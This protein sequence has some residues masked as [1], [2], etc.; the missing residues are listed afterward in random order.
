M[1]IDHSQNEIE[2]VLRNARESDVKFIRLWFTDILGNLKGFAITIEDL[3]DALL[4]GVGFDGA[5][6]EGFARDNESDVRAF[7]DPSTFTILPWRPKDNAT[8]R[9]FCDIHTPQGE[10]FPG[11]PRTILKHNL[12]QLAKSGFT[13]YVGTELEFFYFQNDDS[14]VLLDKDGYFDQNSGQVSGD[15]RRDTVLNLAQMGIPVKY[16]HHEVA[17]SQNEIDLQYTDALTMADNVVTAKLVIKELALAKGVY[18]TFMP[19]PIS[20]INGSGM[21]T[22]Q[23][24]F[25][26]ADNAFYSADDPFHLSQD[27]KYF[28]AGLLK[29]APEITLVT[30]QWINSYKRLVS[31]HEA[32]LFLSW[33][34]LNQSD[35]IRIPSFKTGGESAV[36]IEYRA[37]DPACNPYLAF[38]VML[39]AGLKGISGKYDLMEPRE[40]A[41]PDQASPSKSKLPSS[42][43]EAI[44][45]A[46]DSDLLREALGD[47]IFNGLIRNKKIELDLYHTEVTDFEIK[48]YL[49]ML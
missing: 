5:A 33:A 11:D 27:A 24:L 48:R 26:G 36:R 20:G 45:L 4:H 15:L 12:E 22:Y 39:A 47:N 28:V 37:P 13:Y 49:S 35:L 38:S 40:P 32:P 21:H 44:S 2:F 43:E 18:A 29:H 19:K 14:P 8:A 10:P 42:L 30:N 31:G 3:E 9:M 17:P 41:V 6:I 25:K 23:S 46:E 7:P 34:H 16:S 1:S